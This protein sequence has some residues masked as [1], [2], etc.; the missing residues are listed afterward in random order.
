MIPFLLL[1]PTVSIVLYIFTPSELLYGY[2][3]EGIKDGWLWRGN[4]EKNNCDIVR[5]S[6]RGWMNQ[7]NVISSTIWV[8]C[9]IPSVEGFRGN[10]HFSWRWEEV[11]YCIVLGREIKILTRNNAPVVHFNVKRGD[12]AIP[13]ASLRKSYRMLHR[14]Y[15]FIL[16]MR[17][18]KFIEDNQ[19][20]KI[21]I[22]HS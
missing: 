2:P 17:K 4:W 11:V 10:R 12:R 6:C 13:A 8:Q 5:M 19:C 22:F 16:C 15:I 7:E 1:S 18:K 21:E 14:P 9:K 20:Q 3:D